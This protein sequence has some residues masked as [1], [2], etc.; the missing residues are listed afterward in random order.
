VRLWNVAT[1]KM[2]ME[3]GGSRGAINCLAYRPDGKA[4]ATAENVGVRLWEV[5]TGKQVH[6]WA[7]GQ[8]WHLAF[9]PDGKTLAWYAD[10]EIVLQ[11][12]DME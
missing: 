5:S 1:E 11:A 10:S 8:V 4:L 7:V 12:I 3:F 9:T 6:N 2:T